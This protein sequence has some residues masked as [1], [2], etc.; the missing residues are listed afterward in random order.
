MRLDSKVRRGTNTLAYMSEES[1]TKKKIYITLTPGQAA[2]SSE[3][4]DLK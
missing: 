2:A 3:V 4:K 1:E